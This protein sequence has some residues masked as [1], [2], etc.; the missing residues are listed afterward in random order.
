MALGEG[1]KGVHPE[2]SWGNWIWYVI[3]MAYNFSNHRDLVSLTSGA[4]LNSEHCNCN[5]PLRHPK[6]KSNNFLPFGGTQCNKATFG[7]SR[8]D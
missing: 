8:P 3:S 1:G 4:I 2:C 6:A 7:N 5:A